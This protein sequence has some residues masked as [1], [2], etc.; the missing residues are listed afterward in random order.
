MIDKS[1]SDTREQLDQNQLK[2]GFGLCR[3]DNLRQ[4]VSLTRLSFASYMSEYSAFR[5]E[6]LDMCFMKKGSKYSLKMF[7]AKLST[8]R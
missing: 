8:R 6:N 3:H 5:F 2:F 7:G 1:L 4:I